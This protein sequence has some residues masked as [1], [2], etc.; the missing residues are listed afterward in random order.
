MICDTVA[1]VQGV[2]APSPVTVTVIDGSPDLNSRRRVLDGPDAVVLRYGDESWVVRQGRRSRIDA[3]D[4]AVLLPLGLTPEQVEHARPMS[5]ALFD[6]LPVGP[7][8]AVPF[9]PDAGRPPAF[10]NAPGRWE[11]SSPPAIGWA[12][13]VF[14]STDERRADRVAG[15]GAHSAERRGDRGGA[16]A[17]VAPQDLA[18]MPVVT[19][20]DLGLPGGAPE[21][22]GHE[23]EPVHLLVVG[24][25][26]R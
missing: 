25:L 17:V 15:G 3:A 18:K 26:Q 21:G 11:L 12:A 8:L 19:G 24:A 9:V 16:P 23:G 20:L 10:P 7:E 4:R 5:Q 13:T 2:G 14:G 22:R 1:N 6:A